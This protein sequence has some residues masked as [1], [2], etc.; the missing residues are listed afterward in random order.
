MP[1]PTSI[2]EK[3]SPGNGESIAKVCYIQLA[4]ALC[5]HVHS[6]EN[7]IFH[8][9]TMCPQVTQALSELALVYSPIFVPAGP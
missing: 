6:V 8:V 3:D 9:V 2:A 7:E 1:M 5:Q 4:V